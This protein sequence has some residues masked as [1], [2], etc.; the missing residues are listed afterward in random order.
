LFNKVGLISFPKG[1]NEDQL[2]EITIDAGAEDVVTNDDGSVDVLTDPVDF[3]TVRAALES[4]ALEPE[5]AEVTMRASVTSS[6]G[7]KEAASMMKL[8]E[9]LDDLDDVQNV[10]SNADIP[11]EILQSL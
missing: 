11:D 2:M 3:D 10:Y 1:V 6:L 9:M 8:L 4:A 5:L 7:E